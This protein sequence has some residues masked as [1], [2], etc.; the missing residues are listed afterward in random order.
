MLPTFPS[1]EGSGKMSIL[2]KFVLPEC[3]YLSL[4]TVTIGGADV[5]M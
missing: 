3:S 4:E 5:N 1:V 2:I